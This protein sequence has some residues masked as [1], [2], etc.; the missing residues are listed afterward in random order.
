MLEQVDV[1]LQFGHSVEVFVFV[2]VIADMEL[3][4]FL[5]KAQHNTREKLYIFVYVDDIFSRDVRAD[6]A[7]PTDAVKQINS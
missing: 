5:I 6:F 1:R 2:V 3:F 7:P 4:F